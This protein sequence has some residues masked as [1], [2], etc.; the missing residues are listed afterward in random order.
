M[1]KR[2]L[3]CPECG[4]EWVY[5]YWQWTFKAQFHVFN[6]LKW[7]DKRR[8]KCPKCGKKSWIYSEKVK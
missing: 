7:K 1:S 2:K 8:T 6:F 3:Q 5:G 4:Y